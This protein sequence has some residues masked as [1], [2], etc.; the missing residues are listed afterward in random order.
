[1]WL[2][3]IIFLIK[4]WKIQDQFW[5][6]IRDNLLTKESS[7]R[8]KKKVDHIKTQTTIGC[9][10]FEEKKKKSPLQYVYAHILTNKRKI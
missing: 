4:K 7:L 10:A 1:M 2:C 3:T 6:S 8:R 9:F 5:K